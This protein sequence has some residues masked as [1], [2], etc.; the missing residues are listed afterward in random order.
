M[1][2]K[3]QNTTQIRPN[4]CCIHSR[5]FSRL[6]PKLIR[7]PM[8]PLCHLIRWCHRDLMVVMEPVKQCTVGDMTHSQPS[9]LSWNVRW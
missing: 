9:F 7:S 4:A 8:V 2:H 6:N 1:S 5:Q 3:I